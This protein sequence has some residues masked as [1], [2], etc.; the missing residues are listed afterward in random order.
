MSF[1]LIFKFYAT[2]HGII[3]RV[4]IPQPCK[5]CVTWISHQLFM[6]YFEGWLA[7]LKQIHF[8][9]DRCHSVFMRNFY[10]THF[11]TAAHNWMYLTQACSYIVTTWCFLLRFTD[12]SDFTHKETLSQS[13]SMK[14]TYLTSWQERPS[15]Y[16]QPIRTLPYFR[17]IRSHFI[18][19][20]PSWS[21][22]TIQGWFSD[23]N[24]YKIKET[25]CRSEYIHNI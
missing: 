24:K 6:S 14:A 12:K 10:L 1:H 17:T 22:G 4:C 23:M 3:W 13:A 8:T 20:M 25:R 18:W 9:K 2:Y 21:R 19:A 11:S 15:V 16:T 7:V 5:V